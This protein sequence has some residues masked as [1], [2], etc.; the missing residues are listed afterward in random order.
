M[1]QPSLSLVSALLITSILPLA[2]LLI[3]TELSLKYPSKRKSIGTVVAIIGI[4]EIMGFFMLSLTIEGVTYR[5]P[6]SPRIIMVMQGSITLIGG[7]V[8][9]YYAKT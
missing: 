8:M 7:L 1:A 6:F 5:I 3:A 9:L 4:L 2:I